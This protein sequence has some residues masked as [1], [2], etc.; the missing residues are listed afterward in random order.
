M[1]KSNLEELGYTVKENGRVDF[2][3]PPKGRRFVPVPTSEEDIRCRGVD[4]RFVTR[5]RFS[6]TGKLVVMETVDEAEAAG[7]DAYVAME[8]ADCKKEERKSRCT[9]VSPKTGKEIACPDCI[10]CYGDKCPKKLGT[11]VYE[12]GDISYENVAETVKSSVA[13]D[14]PTADAAVTNVMWESFREKLRREI[15]VLAD[16]IEWDEFGYT[17]NEIMKKLHKDIR[18][19]SWY[20]SQWDRIRKRWH[21]YYNA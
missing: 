11:V 2:S 1:G 12:D 20:Y 18:K 21:A 7:A 4:R 19:T 10:S 15:P 16:I 14:D 6:G 3:R 17:R 8:K 5:H 13:T 9:V